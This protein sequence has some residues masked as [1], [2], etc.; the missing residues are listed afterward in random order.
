[1]SGHG[2]VLAAVALVILLVMVLT[3]L[4]SLPL[5]NAS[6]VDVVWGAGF[7]VTAWTVWIVGDGNAGR[8]DLLT[9]MVTIWGL[10]LA[11]YLLWRNWGE[12]EDFR[13]QSMR[14]RAG[15][16][17]PIRSLATVFLLQGALM[18]VVSL[19]VQLAATPADP[20]LGALAVVGVALWG[21]GF[22]LRDR[23]RRATRPVQGRSRER[24]PGHGPGALAVHPSPQ[25]LRRLLRV[26]GDLPRRRRVVADALVRDHRSP[27]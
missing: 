14:R 9:A 18:W 24:R 4:V 5:R 6:I 10:R 15:D 20:D 12:G 23:R 3:W 19:P 7:V 22:F 27:P 26:V 13:Y 1:M 21:V 17:F 2:D 25:L 16:S 8:I 11:G